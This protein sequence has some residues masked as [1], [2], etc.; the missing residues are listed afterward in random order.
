MIAIGTVML[1]EW[2]DVLENPYVKL[3][4][5]VRPGMMDFFYAVICV[6]EMDL[7]LKMANALK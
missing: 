5:C 7:P 2:D 3:L 1:L 6:E 4:A